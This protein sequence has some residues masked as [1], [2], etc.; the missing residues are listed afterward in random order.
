MSGGS[1]EAAFFQIS[2]DLVARSLGVGWR[3]NG[4]G[5]AGGIDDD[6]IDIVSKLTADK[7]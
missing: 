5:M 2:P 3:M 6:R 1:G 4:C 7:V